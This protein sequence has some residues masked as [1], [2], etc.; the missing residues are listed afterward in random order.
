MTVR[1]LD[2][3]FAPKSVA[4]IGASGQPARVGS[5]VLANL[6]R[7]GFAGPVWPVNP[8]YRTLEGLPCYPD[9]RALPGIPDLA[10]I[11]VPPA[12]VPQQIAMLGEIGCRAA[13]VLTAGFDAA[14]RQ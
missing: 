10:V 3:L 9:V 6:L 5:V 7:G 13:V 14:G 11:V 2:K 4:V 12:A 1:N 8:K